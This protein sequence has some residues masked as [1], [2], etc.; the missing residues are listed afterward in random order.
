MKRHERNQP[1]PSLR[2]RPGI[3]LKEK[4]KTTTNLGFQ[5]DVWSDHLRNVR[6][7]AARDILLS[8]NMIH[9]HSSRL[10]SVKFLSSLYFLFIGGNYSVF[11]SYSWG[12]NLSNKDVTYADRMRHWSDRLVCV[13]THTYQWQTVIHHIGS[14]HGDVLLT[15][16]WHGWSPEKIVAKKLFRLTKITFQTGVTALTCWWCTIQVRK[17][18]DFEVH[19]WEVPFKKGDN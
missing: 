1:C 14:D 13:H 2:F 8:L 7:I 17:L 3:G 10:F 5:V 19:E 16:H 4:S 18:S 9:A 12:Q 15:Q 6:S 11:G